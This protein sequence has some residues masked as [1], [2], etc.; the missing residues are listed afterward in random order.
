MGSSMVG[1]LEPA[2]V[3]SRSH[4]ALQRGLTTL[5]PTEAQEVR[6]LKAA[7]QNALPAA[8]REQ[9]REYERMRA[10]RTTL[11]FEDRQAMILTARAVRALPDG[12]R[13]RLKVVW[14]RVVAAGLAV[15]VPQPATAAASP[16][17]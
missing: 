10:H 12:Q 14:A 11:P 17:P 8:E 16:A 6:D 13:Q 1:T 9:L 2:E 15:R 7:L 4:E 3:F 5:G